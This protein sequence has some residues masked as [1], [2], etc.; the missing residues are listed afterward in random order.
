MS[1]KNSKSSSELLIWAAFNLICRIQTNS[2]H[3]PLC[4]NVLRCCW[5]QHVWVRLTSTLCPVLA[6]FFKGK[7][8]LNVSDFCSG[9]ICAYTFWRQFEDSANFEVNSIPFSGQLWDSSSLLDRHS[10]PLRQTLIKL[11]V[12][13]WISQLNLWHTVLPEC[14]LYKSPALTDKGT[15][16]TRLATCHCLLCSSYW[17]GL[18]SSKPKKTSNQPKSSTWAFR[19]EAKGQPVVFL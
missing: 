4:G 19:L 6:Y 1:K 8:F 16:K 15:I 13:V 2:L 11:C 7:R 3:M 10:H 18:Q 12:Q 5:K 14:C 9:V 17:K